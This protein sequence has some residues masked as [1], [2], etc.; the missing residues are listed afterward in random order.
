[1]AEPKEP[2]FLEVDVYEYNEHGL[3]PSKV[4][5]GI[6]REYRDPKKGFF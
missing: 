6:L 3:R 1:M 5:Q 4:S 2:S